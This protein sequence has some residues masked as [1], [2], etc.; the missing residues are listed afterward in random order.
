MFGDESGHVKGMQLVKNE[1]IQSGEGTLKAQPTNQ[2]EEIPTGL[3][4]HSIGYHGVAL[5]GMPFDTRKGV[6][7]HRAGRVFDPQAGETLPGLYAAGWI[8]RGPYG[9]IGTNK[10]DARETVAAMLADLE[11]GRYL[12]PPHPDAG[13]VKAM[14]EHRQPR[15]VH[16]KD[17]LRLDQIEV[18]RG[19]AQ[20]RPR[21]KF[22]VVADMLD[23][24]EI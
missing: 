24:M 6:I 4:F 5:P 23:H 22:T 9:V 11:A 10:Q 16:F 13:E 17:W 21:D 2:Y 1:L 3:V 15:F 19:M 8:K 7:H 20:N 12:N 14:L 18:A